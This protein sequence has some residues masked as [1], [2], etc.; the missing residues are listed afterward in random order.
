MRSWVRACAGLAALLLGA[1]GDVPGPGWGF[2]SRRPHV[3]PPQHSLG[4][5]L[6]LAVYPSREPGTPQQ[7]ADEGECYFLASTQTGVDP[8]GIGQETTD[9]SDVW[10]QNTEEWRSLSRG[11]GAGSIM[12]LGLGRTWVRSVRRGPARAA[13][14]GRESL[15]RAPP[16]V[17]GPGGSVG[18]L[19][20]GA[21][22]Q[23]QQNA[24]E[25]EAAEE[26]EPFTRERAGFNRQFSACLETRG[27][28]VK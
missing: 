28:I 13:N 19:I 1:W 26:S 22:E 18:G 25:S 16:G 4:T 12:G 14:L 6:G 7:E 21:K 11:V 27:Y 15:G 9:P 3:Q 24:E 2:T 23:G 20:G 8:L 17:G 5:A 10:Q